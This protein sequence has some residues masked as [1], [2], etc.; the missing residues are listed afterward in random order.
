MVGH[1]EKGKGLQS[2]GWRAELVVTPY[3]RFKGRLELWFED[4]PRARAVAPLTAVYG[5]LLYILTLAMEEDVAAGRDE[6]LR[7]FRDARLIARARNRLDRTV[8]AINT[9][10]VNVGRLRGVIKDAWEDHGLEGKP[11]VVVETVTNFGY[12]IA[13]P[14]KLRVDMPDKTPE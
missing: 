2:G 12:R 6:A 14:I 9:I 13:L 10:K 1:L 7:G 3:A 5:G 4:E 11:P 8:V